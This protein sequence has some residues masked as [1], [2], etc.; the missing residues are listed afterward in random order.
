MNYNYIKAAQVIL[1]LLFLWLPGCETKKTELIWNRSLFQLGSQSSPRT[2]DLN[3]DGVQDIV[4]GAGMA[5]MAK[6]DMGVIA[7]DGKTGDLLWKQ[8]TN[9]HMVGSA[10]FYDISGDG[11]ADVFIGGRNN[12]LKAIDGKSGS[13]I[14]EYTYQY[15]QD[16]ILQYARFNFYNSVLIPDQNEDGYPDLLTVNGGNWDALP[17]DTKDRYPGVLMLFSLTDGK[18][19]AADTM[20][21]GKESYMSPGYI[22]AQDN[23]GASIIFG[24]GGETISGSLY[25]VTLSD[26]LARRLATSKLLLTEQNHGFIAPPVLA[27][28][29]Q[30]GRLD[31]IVVSHAG[32]ITALNGTNDQLIWQKKFTGVESSN[33]MAVGQFTDDEVPDFLTVM[34]KG[35]WPQYQSAHQLALDGKTGEIIWRDSIG[36]FSL[37]S[38]VMYDLNGDGR[39]EAILNTNL[40]DCNITFSEDTLSPESITYYIFYVDIQKGATSQI[41]QITDHKNIF[42][43]PWIGDLDQDSYLDIVYP[44][45]FN[46]G[47]LQRFLGMKIKRI[48]THIPMRKKITWGQ[49]MGSEGK[50]IYKNVK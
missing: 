2:S 39:D 33:A 11:I 42:S 44:L 26:F 32:T 23:T 9:A 21:D 34:N 22:P 5:E 7:V 35:I 40:Y 10:T 12:Q 20:P 29:T 31:M 6:T 28:I 38:A 13:L 36:C 48:S 17:Y 14:W 46:P 37:T 24:S 3:G 4:M 43:T 50:G 47:D 41:D 49:Y 30:D 1:A 27:D 25:R 16:P 45:Y 18:I 8:E 19:L 15:Q